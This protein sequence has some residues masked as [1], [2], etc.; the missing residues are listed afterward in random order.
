MA[1]W[2]GL[3]LQKICD[4]LEHILAIEILAGVRAIEAQSPLATTPEIARIR[5][6][7]RERVPAADKDCRHDTEI[8]AVTSAIVRGEFLAALAD[9]SELDLF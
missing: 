2:A 4:N 9:A 6:R 7:L 8:A 5:T 3:K 1:P